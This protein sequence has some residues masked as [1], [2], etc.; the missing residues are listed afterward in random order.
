MLS[1]QTNLD[2]SVAGLIE[3]ANQYNGHDNITAIAVRAKVR[4]N[5]DQLQ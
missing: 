1:S 5:L 4:P 2:Q 3:L